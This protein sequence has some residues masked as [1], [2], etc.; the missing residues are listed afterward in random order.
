MKH[1][2]VKLIMVIT[3]F[4]I[5]PAQGQTIKLG[6]LVP[7]GSTWYMHLRDMG[8]KW[9]KATGGK[10]NFKIYP[11]GVIGDEADM[12]RKMRIGQLHA[13]AV[14][15]AGLSCIFPEINA[16]QMPLMF[17]SYEELDHVRKKLEPE[18]E[19]LLENRGF[20]VLNW[21]DAGWVHI[22][23]QK[24][25]IYPRDLKIH[26][27]HIFVWAGGTESFNAWKAA[28]FHPVEVAA[29]DIFMSLQTGLINTFTTTPL[30]AL[31]YQWFALAKNMCDLAYAPLCGAT[32]ITKKKWDQIPKEIRP[33]LLNLARSSGENLKKEIRNLD[34]TAVNI[35]KKHGLVVNPL[36]QDAMNEWKRMTE[37]YLYPELLSK[38]VPPDMF[39]K[40]KEL[41]GDYRK[42]KRK[43][44]KK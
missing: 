1:L 12:V 15:F 9:K 43:M 23:S 26:D 29:P 14:T 17:N 6:T 20:I 33:E 24:P 44:E 3:L 40:V 5:H 16:F 22:F 21:G 25:V 19:E 2:I 34:K 8:E 36:P 35:M 13:A 32:I 28:G 38:K 11:G 30:V 18:L 10:L 37:K 7:D 42:I 4:S 27:Q 31:S 39:K 41:L